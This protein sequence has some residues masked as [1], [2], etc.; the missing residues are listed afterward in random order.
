MILLIGSQKGGTGKSTTAINLAA[1]LSKNGK[2]VVLVD[3]DKQGSS[4]RWV[5]DRNELE[6]VPAI[7]CIQ[8]YDNLVKTLKDLN[9]RYQYVI[10]DPAG[11]D[12]KELRTAMLIAD[13]LIVP[14]KCS[15]LD[16]DTLPLLKEVIDE[17]MD[18]N[19][20]LKVHALISM[21]PT[22]PS[23]S[24]INNTIEAINNYE[25][26]PLKTIISER[27]VYQDSISEGLGV[28]EMDN[29]K[30]RVE[31]QSLGREIFGDL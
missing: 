31:I 24:S 12:S 26:V 2:D 27:K 15:Q 6:N 17:A 4:H 9:E 25:L 28:I 18:F 7:H 3:A 19:P 14:L 13:K 30:A 22:N 8:K 11:R 21:A 5:Q 1:W 23:I 29:P 10:V 16:L 20:N